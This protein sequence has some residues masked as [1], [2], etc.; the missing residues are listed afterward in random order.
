MTEIEFLNIKEKS[1]NFKYTSMTYED[2]GT[3]RDFSILK[4]NPKVI[5]VLGYNR[6]SKKNEYHWASNKAKDLINAIGTNNINVLI[7]FIPQNWV[8]EFEQSEFKVYAIYNDYFMNS[9]EAIKCETKPEFLVEAECESASKVTISCKGQS[10]GFTGQTV[11]WMQKWIVGEEPSAIAS[12]TKNNEVLVHRNLSGEIVGIICVATYSHESEKGAITWI[13]EVAVHPDYQRQGIARKLILQGL[14]FGKKHGAT[15][16]FL[17]ADECNEHAI[18][19][20]ES[21]GF[22]A[23]KDEAEIDMIK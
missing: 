11:E 22:K 23:D 13:R 16:A 14:D 9:M 8:M 5:L 20:Y 15:R 7:T 18:H 19:L 10:R 3:L 21:I 1:D 6:E 17:A 4:D 12:G 2:Y